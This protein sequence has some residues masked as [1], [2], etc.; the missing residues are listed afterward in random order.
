MSLSIPVS[1]ILL[2]LSCTSCKFVSSPGPGGSQ[3]SQQ[4]WQR[5][6]RVLGEHPVVDGH[7]DFPMG[8]R[9]LLKNDVWN[10]LHFD[11]DLTQQ[12]PW[13]SYYANHCDLPRMR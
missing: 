13:S 7:N 5:V 12:E 4:T 9:V 10:S 6:F 3:R 2:W 11:Q 1:L 8:V